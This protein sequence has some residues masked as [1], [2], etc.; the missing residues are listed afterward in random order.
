M[1]EQKILFLLFHVTIMIFRCTVDPN[2]G[3]ISHDLHENRFVFQ[4]FEYAMNSGLPTLQCNA[5]YC[6]PSDPNACQ[7]TCN[8]SVIKLEEEEFFDDDH[9]ELTKEESGKLETYNFVLS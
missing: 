2:A 4:Y 1:L 6:S 5:T 8:S 9:I 3:L 7:T